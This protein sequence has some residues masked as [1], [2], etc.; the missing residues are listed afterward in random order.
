MSHLLAIGCTGMLAGA[1]RT[2]APGHEHV[3]IVSRHAS[4][5]TL[6]GATPVDADWSDADAFVTSMHVALVSRPPVSGCLLWAHAS[7]DA[8]VARVLGS[9]GD[10]VRVVQVLGSMHSDPRER[11][12]GWREACAPGVQYTSVALGRVRGGS[13]WRW[14]THD[15][16]CDGTLR[17]WRTR[18][19]VVVGELGG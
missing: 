4:A 11:A 12:E 10:G 3:T 5:F 15:E 16:V 1:L 18:K 14:L 2:L 9:L 13:S 17:A 8:S 19:D 7:A 6:P